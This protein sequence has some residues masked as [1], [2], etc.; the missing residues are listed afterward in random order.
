[1]PSIPSLGVAVALSLIGFAGAAA[2]DPTTVA[3]P[4]LP[5]PHVRAWQVGLL[6]PDR[7]QHVTLSYTSGLMVGFASEAPAAAAAS[8]LAI[9]VAK[10]LWDLHRGGRFDPLDLAAA[11]VGA[12]GAALTTITLSR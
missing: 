5:S 8:A 1:M 3:S 10:E 2:A 11:A 9:G 7:L 12:A 6:R 4:P